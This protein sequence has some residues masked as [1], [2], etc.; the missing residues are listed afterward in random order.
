[1]YSS[2]I[3]S[4]GMFRYAGILR[5]ANSKLGCVTFPQNFKAFPRPI[6]GRDSR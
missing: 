4:L 5:R 6:P 3:F 2:E 1:M